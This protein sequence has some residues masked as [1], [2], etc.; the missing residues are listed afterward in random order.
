M[1][2]IQRYRF[3]IERDAKRAISKAY[4]TPLRGSETSG[5]DWVLF[6]DHIADKTAAV[7]QAV[8]DERERLEALYKKQAE[9]MLNT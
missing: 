7:A 2:E 6:S 5:S 1:K 3:I 9:R 4:I 8:K